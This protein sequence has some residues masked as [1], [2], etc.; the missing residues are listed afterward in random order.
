MVPFEASRVALASLNSADSEANSRP[1]AAHWNRVRKDEQPVPARYRVGYTG[2]NACGVRQARA[3]RK[4]YK[5]Q[6]PLGL[7]RSAPAERPD[8]FG[9]VLIGPSTVGKPNI[10]EVS[11]D[12]SSDKPKMATTPHT[13]NNRTQP[14]VQGG[15]PRVW[16]STVVCPTLP[17]PPPFS[18]PRVP[19]PRFSHTPLP[20][21][22]WSPAVLATPDPRKESSKLGRYRW[23]NT[24][25]T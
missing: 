18:L 6:C 7:A 9:L 24:S 21:D 10:Y 23:T 15:P 13:W 5:N 20:S 2:G 16:S 3:S 11:I 14:N 17:F 12:Q 19:S 8:Q 22:V 1:E 4:K 25:A